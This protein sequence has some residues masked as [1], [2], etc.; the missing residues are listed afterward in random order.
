MNKE[1]VLENGKITTIFMAALLS[2]TSKFKD[3]NIRM[4]END[5]DS[6]VINVTR[7]NVEELCPSWASSVLI[8]NMIQYKICAPIFDNND[9]SIGQKVNAVR[10]ALSAYAK[11][12]GI[13]MPA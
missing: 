13:E 12:N 10:N 3:A 6:S 11:N 7:E 1:L 9:L 2:C 4:V 5:E 8:S